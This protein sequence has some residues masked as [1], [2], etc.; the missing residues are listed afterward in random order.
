M[1]MHP[2][3]R[4]L[5][6]AAAAV[7]LVTAAAFAAD[8]QAK[9]SSAGE[10]PREVPLETLLATRFDMAWIL[11]ATRTLPGV[12]A[13]QQP[14]DI[15][16]RAKALATMTFGPTAGAPPGAVPETSTRSFGDLVAAVLA[17]GDDF[18]ARDAW[19]S[20]LQA[21][22]PEIWRACGAEL[23]Q[24]TR[25]EILRGPQWDPEQDDDR[26]GIFMGRAF[27][28]DCE[29]QRPWSKIDGDPLAQ[30]ALGL[31]LA[32]LETIKAIENDYTLYPSNVGA[33]YE[34]IHGTAGS[35]CS[36]K[37]AQGR[38]VNAL[39]MKFRQDLPFPYTHFD[40]DL[41]IL[42]RLDDDGHLVTDIY[43]PSED[44]DWMAGQDVFVPLLDG[45]GAF[46]G[47]LCARVFGFDIDGVPD[48]EEDVRVALRSSLGNL[49][50]RAD[51]AFADH[52]AQG[53][54]PRTLQ[55]A[56]PAFTL[57]GAR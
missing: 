44:F 54:T 56:I 34:F 17:C 16:K 1:A 47:I 43:S 20:A 22:R 36:A 40:C 25:A 50:R 32:D 12:D 29:G 46:V 26:D 7:L 42:N 5:T 49:K 48:G 38:P 31:L 37:D 11:P 9:D 57:R 15:V 51:R 30:Q 14:V 35:F 41:R 2:C 28:A 4:H 3:P 45:D 10:L 6:R 55:G 23:V 24:L 21:Q 19:L 33:S 39:G 27:R 52:L 8:P 18:R 53:G 13:A